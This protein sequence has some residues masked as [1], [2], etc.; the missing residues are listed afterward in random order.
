MRG[1]GLKGRDEKTKSL[2]DYP[3]QYTYKTSALGPNGLPVDILHDFYIPALKRSIRYD[4]MAGY[5]RSTSLAAA[6][7]G[8]SAFTASGGKMRLVVGAYLD[9]GD[10]QAILQGDAQR[11]EARLNQELG[12]PKAWPENVSRGVELLCWMMAQGYLEIRVAFRVHKETGKPLPMSAVDDGY[13][14][15]KW[16]VLTDAKGNRLYVAGSLNESQHALVVNAENIDVHADWWSPV[17]RKRADDAETAFES[18]WLDRLPHLRIMTLPEAIQEKLVRIGNETRTPVEIDGSTDI[19]PDIPPPS[20]LERLQFA[21]IK[22]G[23]KLPWG[24]FVGMETAPVKPWPHQEV[25]ARRLVETWPY[26]YL[27]CDE[28]GLGKTIEAG[29]AI[30]SLYLSGLVRRVLITPPAGITRQWQREMASKFMM[31]F[32]RAVSG[33]KV[34]HEYIHPLEEKRHAKSLYAP[35]LCIVSTALLSRKDRIEALRAAERFDIA[36]VDEAHYARRKNPKDGQ[37]TSPRYGNFYTTLRDILRP[38]SQ[39]LWMATAT[40]MQLDWIEVYD[41]LSLTNRTGPF[42]QDPTLTWKYYEALGALVRRNDIHTSEWELL[43]KAIS[44]VKSQDPFYWLYL[45][46]AVMDGRIRTPANLWFEHGRIPKQPDRN[47]MLRLIFASAPLSRVMLRH[48]RALLEIYQKRGELGENLP[49][50]IILPIP[51]I[52]MTDREKQAYEEL[53]T[54]CRELTE[55]IREQ[56][57][58]SSLISHLGFYLSFLRLRY[59]SSLNAIWKSLKRRRKRVQATLGYQLGAEE[60]AEEI[61]ELESLI[62]ETEDEEDRAIEALLRHRSP[63]DLQWEESRLEEMIQTLDD[64]SETPSKMKELFSVLDQRR[65]SGGRFQQTVIFTRFYDTLEDILG[66]LRAAD[67][68]ML[69]GSYSGKG[70][71]YID[72]KSRQIR[73][74]DREEVKHRFIRGEIDILICTDAAAEGLN[75]QTADLLVNYDLPW[76]PMKVE[77]RI[78]RI[79]RIGQKFDE[80]FVLNLC[81]AESTEQKVYGRLLNRLALASNVVGAQQLS[82]LPVLPQEFSELAAGTLKYETLEKRA[83][84]RIAEQRKRDESMEIPAKDLYDMYVRWREQQERSRPPITLENIWEALCESRYLRDLGCRHPSE[85]EQNLFVLGNIGGVPRNT[86]LTVDRKLYERGEQGLERLH[87]ASY[88]DPFFEAVMKE[89]EGFPLPDCIHRLTESVEGTNAE[90]IAYVIRCVN[91]SGLPGHRL[92]KSFE[93]LKGLQLDES[94]AIPEDV[95]EGFQNDLRRETRKAFDPTRAVKRIELEN[96]RA[97]MAQR[98]LDLF[99]GESLVLP[100]DGSEADLFWPE[101]KRLD[102]LIQE[103]DQLMIRDVQIDL[104]RKVAPHL[105]FPVPVPKVGERGT[106]TVPIFLVECAVDAGC[107]LADGMRIKKSELTVGTVKNRISREVRRELNE[108]HKL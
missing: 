21:L 108:L 96:Q 74:I 66:R 25:V 36:L 98:L 35:D 73:K 63:E 50:R 105:L 85:Q 24:R 16:A 76:N 45:S 78:G 70:G 62:I 53:E 34:Q 5:F 102:Q 91:E 12:E 81:Y 33:P 93:D 90:I 44:A 89:F 9:E 60:V 104:L 52:L 58:A 40:P 99:L 19:R 101:L 43:R 29:L 72:T 28:V 42:Q 106:I 80:V 8:F 37:R 22:D 84:E 103:R 100:F 68:S 77:Q 13:V 23:P 83:K 4:R 10:I 46:E 26:S 38:R 1:A 57:K 51:T 56:S 6:S 14:H 31:P 71:Q 2:K 82:L 95:L 48:T 61:L 97:G 3:W 54:Y 11:M 20:A 107:R 59:A 17:D 32:A 79:D 27:L 92:I 67:P 87:F 47:P 94:G 69:I 18:I 86:A 65:M 30:R 49:K 88:G 41:L 15:E 39:T 64:Q 75:L 7:Q 55:K